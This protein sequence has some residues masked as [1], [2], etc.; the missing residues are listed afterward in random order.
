MSISSGTICLAGLGPKFYDSPQGSPRWKT[1]TEHQIKPCIH[2]PCDGE[3][4]L[5]KPTEP[6][7]G[8]ATWQLGE[9]WWNKSGGWSRQRENNCETR[10]SI[11]R[12]CLQ[13]NEVGN[14]TNVCSRSWLPC[15]VVYKALNLY[16][17]WTEGGPE[18]GRYNRGKSGWFD[19]V[20][21]EDWFFQLFCRTWED[22]QARKFYRKTTR[23][24]ICRWQSLI[25]VKNISFIFLPP[26]SPWRGIL[27]TYEN[28]LPTNHWRVEEDILWTSVL[29]SRRIPFH[30]WL[31]DCAT[32]WKIGLHKLKMLKLVSDNVA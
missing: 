6:A 29:P 20:C 5:Q 7:E 24:A 21:F 10:M 22:R 1:V 16:D 31:E 13:F 14:I 30:L 4:V 3:G 26:N 15:Y 25:N 17:I 8:C 11:S 19:S 28:L 2:W 9:L 32:K 23:A 18:K 27:Y 12:A